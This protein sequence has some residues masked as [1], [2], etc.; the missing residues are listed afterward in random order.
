MRRGGRGGGFSGGPCPKADLLT[1][2]GRDGTVRLWDAKSGKEG[3][4]FDAES[5]AVALSPDGALLA[6]GRTWGV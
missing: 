1:S 5:R 6:V 2:S 3:H 4:R